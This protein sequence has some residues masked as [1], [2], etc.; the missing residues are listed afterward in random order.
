MNN[1]LVRRMLDAIDRQ[2]C[3]AM[4]L[5]TVS[6]QVGRQPAHLGRL[7]RQE[8]GVT[9]R[10][11]LTRGR[12]ERATELI[13]EGVKIEA[14]ALSVGYRSKKNFYQQFKRHYGTTPLPYR[15]QAVPAVSEPRGILR[16]RLGPEPIR[17]E[18]DVSLGALVSTVR[19]SNRAWRLAVRAQRLMLKH[20]NRLRIGILLTNEVGR[21]LGANPAATTLT[22]YSLNEL[23]QL[24]PEDLFADSLSMETRGVWQFLML[25]PDPPDQSLNATVRTKAGEGISIRLVTFRNFLWGRRELSAMLGEQVAAAV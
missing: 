9:F 14:I 12:L 13:R 1:I 25:R 15:S 5:R 20:F 22:G 8:V 11:Y 21:Y 10:E 6:A 2:Y 7:F 4:T 19:I 3:E 17:R 24:S 16:A 18:S 23:R